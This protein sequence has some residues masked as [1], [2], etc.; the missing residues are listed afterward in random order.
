MQTQDFKVTISVNAIPKEAIEAI[1]NVAG[2]WATNVKGCS[3][4]LNDV[5]TVRFGKTFSVIKVIEITPDEKT[6]WLITD[7][8]LPLFENPKDW[9]N[10][11]IVWELS[12]EN[13]QTTV[14]M[15]HIGL[16][17]GIGCYNDCKKGWTFYITESLKKLITDGKGLPGTGIFSYI[18]SGDKKYEGLLYFKIDPLPDYPEGFLYVDVKATKGERVISAYAFDTYQKE[19]FNPALLKGEHFVIVENKTLHDDICALQDIERAL[20]IN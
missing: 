14:S 6:V 16:I 2:W 13:H 5:F 8:Y 4:N 9:L 20:K 1:N 12:S 15:T 18:I 3:T 7:C 17:P 11:K 19:K 10:T